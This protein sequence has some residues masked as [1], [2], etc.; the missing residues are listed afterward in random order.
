[1]KSTFYS[2]II[3][4]RRILWGLIVAYMLGVHNFYKGEDKGIDDIIK[5]PYTIEHKEAREND[6]P[7]A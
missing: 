6:V 2:L 1:M 4:T 3:R 5:T 7:E